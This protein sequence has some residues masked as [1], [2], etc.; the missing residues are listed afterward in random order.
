MSYIWS[1]EK[2][3]TNGLDLVLLAVRPSDKR[4][5]ALIHEVVKDLAPHRYTHRVHGAVQ[6]VMRKLAEAILE[7]THKFKQGQHDD[8][9]SGIPVHPGM[10]SPG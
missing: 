4:P 6:H 8:V 2:G 3:A 10:D 9:S 5:R 7:P 1:E